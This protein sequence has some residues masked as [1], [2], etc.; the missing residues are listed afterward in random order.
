MRMT[1]DTTSNGPQ[2]CAL[3]VPDSTTQSRL[4]MQHTDN[5][6]NKNPH[7]SIRRRNILGCKRKRVDN[8]DAS[9]L[10]TSS[11]Q[12]GGCLDS[13]RLLDVKTL[14]TL[15]CLWLSP[16][17]PLSWDDQVSASS[18]RGS[19]IRRSRYRTPGEIPVDYRDA[20]GGPPF[21]SKDA[22]SS[23]SSPAPRVLQ[24]EPLQSSDP[25]GNSTTPPI[26]NGTTREEALAHLLTRSGYYTPFGE[27]PLCWVTYNAT[28][29]PHLLNSK[30]FTEPMFFPNPL[31]NEFAYVPGEEVLLPTCFDH[32]SLSI[33]KPIESIQGG[34]LRTDQTYEYTVNLTLDFASILQMQRGTVGDAV[35][36]ST[37][38][39][40]GSQV[41]VQ[42]MHCVLGK[43]GVCAPFLHEQ[44]YAKDYL[45]TGV[46]PTASA[47]GSIHG[48]TH[49]HSNFVLLDLEPNQTVLDRSLTIPLQVNVEGDYFVIAAVQFYTGDAASNVA[50]YRWDMANAM[51]SQN[52]V[53]TYQKPAVIQRVSREVRIISYVIIGG[54]SLVIVFLIVQAIKYRHEQVLQL[55]QG[56][57]LIVFLLSAL[58][59]T[60]CTFMMEPKNDLYC[61]LGNTLVLLPVHLMYAITAGRLWRI[62]AV[63]SPLLVEHM[64]TKSRWTNRFVGAVDALSSSVTLHGGHRPTREVR[65]SIPKR[66][67]ALV[68]TMFVSPQIL[69]QIAELV[70]QPQ[71]LEIEYNSDESI[72]RYTCRTSSNNLGST[73]L[74][75]ALL[76][77]LILIVIVLFVAY[78]SRKLPSLFNETQVIYDSTFICVVLVV[79][80]SGVIVLTD[81]ATTSPDVQYVVVVVVTLSITL[82]STLRIMI[83]KLKM[84][85]K[86]EQVIV[87]KL[88]SDHHRKQREKDFKKQVGDR[89]LLRNVT[90]MDEDYD[91]TKMSF[92]N[93]SFGPSQMSLMNSTSMPSLN[94]IPDP[95]V[96][97]S[98]SPTVVSESLLTASTR[99]RPMHLFPQA[100]TG[101]VT[102]K[103]SNMVMA[104]EELGADDPEQGN[105]NGEAKEANNEQDR[106]APDEPL[107]SNKNSKDTASTEMDESLDVH[108][109]FRRQSAENV[110]TSSAKRDV[111]PVGK[112]SSDTAKESNDAAVES[113]A[114]TVGSSKVGRRRR[115]SPLSKGTEHA[116]LDKTQGKRKSMFG[117]GAATFRRF[118]LIGKSDLMDKSEPSQTSN[119][120]VRRRQSAMSFPNRRKS[121]GKRV[122]LDSRS[123][124]NGDTGGSSRFRP[125]PSLERM[126]VAPDETPARRLVL[127]MIDLQEQLSSVT[128]KV[129]SGLAVSEDDWDLLTSLNEKLYTTF[130]KDVE[131]S[132]REPPEPKDPVTPPPS[133][134]GSRGRVRSR[135]ADRLPPK[136]SRSADKLP[137]Q[138]TIQPGRRSPPGSPKRNQKRKFELKRGSVANPSEVAVAFRNIVDV[139]DRRKSIVKHKNCFVGKEAVDSLVFSGLASSREEAVQIGRAMVKDMHLFKTV[140]DDLEFDDDD[141]LYRFVDLDDYWS[142][143][144]EEEDPES[145]IFP[146]ILEEGPHLG[147]KAHQFREAVTTKDCV[148]RTQFHKAVFIGAEAVDNLVYTGV[149]AT[150]WEAVQL[151]RKLAREY[152]LFCHVTD[153]HDFQDDYL[154]YRYNKDADESKTNSHFF[155]LNSIAENSET[156]HQEDSRNELADK[157]DAFRIYV[158]VRNRK[159][160]LQTLKDVFVGSEA[161]DSLVFAG[162]A[163]SRTEAVELGR[164]LMKELR[165]FAA[166]RGDDKFSDKRHSYYRF[167]DSHL[168]RRNPA[169]ASKNKPMDDWMIQ[170]LRNKAEILQQLV[171]VKDRKYRFRR[172]KS[173]FVGA[174]AVDQMVS[175]G[176]AKTRGEAVQLG[177]AME[178]ELEL[179]KHVSVEK[180]FSD[181]YLFYQF[182]DADHSNG[183]LQSDGARAMTISRRPS[184]HGKKLFQQADRLLDSSS[185][186]SEDSFA[187]VLNSSI[188]SGASN[189]VVSLLGSEFDGGNDSL[190]RVGG[191]LAMVPELGESISGDFDMEAPTL[192][193]SV[194]RKTG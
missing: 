100:S 136:R 60:I 116:D 85:W 104:S 39:T 70:F 125:K 47:P 79:L 86:G 111:S 171:E 146:S 74:L 182:I 6:D 170:D 110:D 77:L 137:A 21:S 30:V 132:W 180:Q 134:A 36:T 31:V 54:A 165:L 108:E 172:Y 51:A 188:R 69:L 145:V 87:S 32:S 67:L 90:G 121:P 16:V 101:D 50:Y 130:E 24:E 22:L 155:E 28:A 4:E 135:S 9:T 45:E 167:H 183:S 192:H 35:V 163:S 64:R 120:P 152:G 15:L 72:G 133:D 127:R 179:F 25:T 27:E 83:P 185:S 189:D 46:K 71:K 89:D 5:N 107:N 81:T 97:D 190:S 169:P 84:I 187:Q 33:Q 88:V 159:Y 13:I 56:D 181:D 66:Q 23:L 140:N 128:Y 112:K 118:P 117:P 93:R 80:G 142:S 65:R 191:I 55:S 176:M 17:H 42:V 160:L 41:A 96:V 40:N 98:V 124:H 37:P 138:I 126:R 161:V 141:R 73:I 29:F 82:N 53:V 91:Y 164:T 151:G 114:E 48:D 154:F 99:S 177:R 158:D 12:T 103:A 139:R 153:D 115:W 95:P 129:M 1:D 105:N 75:Y 174:E 144:E 61:N 58:T 8:G 3:G 122:G 102:A 44:A 20:T 109:I 193:A 162:V 76:A 34:R 19:G 173:C 11:R 14:L 150:R 149:A 57:F 148:Y 143:S 131:F 175:S 18:S 2:H 38:N 106:E 26:T 52:R 119:G 157:A 113:D 43:S 178:R 147:D 184:E 123:A 7:R 168:K 59:A 156:T 78:S 63:I 62:N 94:Y 49:I 194:R 68:V 92:Y 166:V 10:E 186:D